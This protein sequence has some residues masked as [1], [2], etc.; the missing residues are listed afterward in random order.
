MAGGFE[1]SADMSAAKTAGRIP[2][3]PLI[4]GKTDPIGQ[5]AAS[6]AAAPYRGS[7]LRKRRR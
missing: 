5:A 2:K 7:L 3:S 6:A 1:A 4:T